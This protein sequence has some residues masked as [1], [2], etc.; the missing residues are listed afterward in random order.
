MTR[1]RRSFTFH[2]AMAELSGKRKRDSVQLNRST[3]SFYLVLKEADGRIII[4]MGSTNGAGDTALYRIRF[5]LELH[6][7]FE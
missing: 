2:G 6:P 3:I 4:S 1:K 5:L 7:S